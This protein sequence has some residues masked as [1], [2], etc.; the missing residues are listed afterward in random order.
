MKSIESL[1]NQII[2]GDSFQVI[3][4]IPDDSINL[5]V[6]S[7]PYFGCRVYGKETLGR[8]EDPKEYIDHM[9]EFTKDIKRVLAPTGSF[10]LNIGDV[11]FGTK[12]FGRVKGSYLRKTHK[13]Y[14]EHNIV[15]ED[16]KY[17]QYKQ[18]LL[19]PPRIAIKMQDDGWI[20][21]NAIVWE[22]N[23]A[24][25][26]YSDDRRLPVYEYIYHFV[27]S[28]D[29]YFDFKTAKELD[30]H[31]DV[32]RCG[33]EPFGNHQATF[34]EKLIYPLIVTTSKEGDLVLD[35]F[36][37]A[38]TVAIVCKRCKRDYIL[39]ELNNDSCEEARARIVNKSGDWINE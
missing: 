24:C 14:K 26:N 23:N 37:G 10:Y 22:K 11:Y 25:P 38:G 28:K 39:V 34:P 2:N 36:G 35:P 12:G 21:R 19:I 7:P 1:R 29:Y 9:F 30:S 3:K 18:L 27:K 6:T 16:G 33:I 13:H 17:L 4:E 31:R 20:L 8:E 15:E 32:I 5:V